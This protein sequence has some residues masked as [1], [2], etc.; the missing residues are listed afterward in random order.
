MDDALGWIRV[1]IF[2]SQDAGYG[3]FLWIVPY[4]FTQSRLEWLKGRQRID[5]PGR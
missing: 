1:L 3:R 4:S 2:E 5:W